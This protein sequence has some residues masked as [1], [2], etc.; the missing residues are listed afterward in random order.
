MRSSPLWLNEK[1]ALARRTG[2]L[3][4]SGEIL[5]DLS[6]L[7]SRLS[8]KHLILSFTPL[9]TLDRLPLQPN[10]DFLAVDSSDLQNF[11]NFRALPKLTSVSLKN[12]PAARRPHFKLSLAIV[13]GS[14]LRSVNGQQVHSQLRERAAQYPPAAANLVNAGWFAEWPVPDE[15]RFE[16]LTQE[17]AGEAPPA[18]EAVERLPHR[19]EPR[20][21]LADKIR[22][23]LELRG[24]AVDPEAPIDSIIAILEKLLAHPPGVDGGEPA[25]SVEEEQPVPGPVPMSEEEEDN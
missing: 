1:L 10:L 17:F 20:S 9:R 24:H 4:L 11:T 23:L 15:A 21:R 18:P 5:D 16:A 22:A 2:L 13:I 6:I 19:E 25:P 3:D 14:S 7:G 12:T 8:L